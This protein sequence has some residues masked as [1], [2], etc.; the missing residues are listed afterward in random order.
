MQSGNDTVIRATAL[1]QLDTAAQAQYPVSDSTQQ[2]IL[3]M[4]HHQYPVVD[5]SCIGLF[6]VLFQPRPLC[7]K[8]LAK[9]KPDR[10][11][12]Y[13]WCHLEAGRRRKY[14]AARLPCS[15]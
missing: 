1:E 15:I 12:L 7:F 13:L 6:I 4:D 2:R 3:G 9:A 10:F 14:T 5:A 11:A 8:N